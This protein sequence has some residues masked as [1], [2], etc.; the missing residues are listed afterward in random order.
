MTVREA[1][2]YIQGTLK[3]HNIDDSYMEAE[4]LIRHILKISREQL[5][6][7]LDNNLDVKE[8]TSLKLLV[9]RRIQREPLAY[10]VGHKEFYGLDFIV[11]KSVLIPRPETELLVD[12]ALEFTL[13]DSPCVIADVGTGCGAI[14][15]ALAKYLPLAKIYATDISIHALETASANCQRHAVGNRIQLLNGSLLDPIPEPVDLIVANLPYV[16]DS[17]RDKLPA[18]IRLYEPESALAGGID[19]LDSI[20]ELLNA[21]TKLHP[22]GIILAEIG[23][24]Q[25]PAVL[26][27]AKCCFPTAFIELITDLNGI[28]RVISIRTME[29]NVSACCN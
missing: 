23:Y 17:D 19:G 29:S 20:K 18:E 13:K 4:L 26:H 24:D 15:I 10:I 6:L 1:L 22:A 2:S 5:Y 27:Q 8:V 16:K 28:D 9:E 12:K 3:Q 25:G 21:G 14:A 11:N 7:M